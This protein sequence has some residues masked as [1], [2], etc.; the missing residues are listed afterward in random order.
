[1][2]R[3]RDSEHF[4]RWLATAATTNEKRMHRIRGFR[5]LGMLLKALARMTI[6][7]QPLDA[8]KKAA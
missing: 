3:W 5:G 8:V 1:V 7:V 2:K 4:Q 6:K